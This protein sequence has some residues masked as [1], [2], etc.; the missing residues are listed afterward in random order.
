MELVSEAMRRR[1][2]GG[3]TPHA[4]DASAMAAVRRTGRRLRTMMSQRRLGAQ[5]AIA[6]AL[7][8]MVIVYLRPSFA[9]DDSSPARLSGASILWLLALCAVATI[10]AAYAVKYWTHP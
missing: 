4:P 10:G 9:L 8:I 1:H 3:A 2:R 7:S 5:M 6:W